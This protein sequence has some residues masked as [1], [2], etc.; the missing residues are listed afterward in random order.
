MVSWPV[1]VSRMSAACVPALVSRIQRPDTCCGA[2]RADALPALEHGHVVVA[3][4]AEHHR[5]AN[6]A[7]ATADN[8]DLAH[9]KDTI[10]AVRK[11]DD[12]RQPISPPR[13]N[14]RL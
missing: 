8:C 1:P 11:A 12:E 7:E 14:R 4:A 6:A 3:G 13:R 9:D 10:R 2:R 5:R